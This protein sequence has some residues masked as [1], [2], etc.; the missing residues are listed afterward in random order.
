MS[1]S[2]VRAWITAGLIQPQRVDH[3]CYFDFR[4]VAAART[5][6]DLARTGVSLGR[7]RRQLERLKVRTPRAE[8]ARDE[9]PVV[10]PDGRLLL[11]LDD[12]GVAAAD[13]Q[14]HFGFSA[15]EEREAISTL[16]LRPA[17]AAQWHQQELGT[18]RTASSMPPQRP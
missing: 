9:M 17:T 4:Q 1:H 2:S 16:T 15:D 11:R 3:D 18:N 6:C 8:L 12:G 7:L 5:I 10:E 14:L 13:G